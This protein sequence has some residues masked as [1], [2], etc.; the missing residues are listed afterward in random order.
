MAAGLPKAGAALMEVRDALAFAPDERFLADAKLAKFENHAN[1]DSFLVTRSPI[2]AK[3]INVM[4]GAASRRYGSL[5][6]ALIL[7]FSMVRSGC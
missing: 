2:Q 6:P 3:P 5:H 1:C 4:Q 7:D